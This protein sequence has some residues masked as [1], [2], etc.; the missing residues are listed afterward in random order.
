[1]T[2]LGTRKSPQLR[3]TRK[4]PRRPWTYY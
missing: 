4:I 3:V 1:V 2:I